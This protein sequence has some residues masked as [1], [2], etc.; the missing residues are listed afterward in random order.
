MIRYHARWV[1]PVDAASVPRGTVAVDGD[2]IAYVGPRAGAPP[3][4]DRDLGDVALLPGLVAAHTDGDHAAATLAGALACGVT[5]LGACTTDGSLLHAMRDVGLRGVAYLAV[6]GPAPADRAASF[7]ALREG[8]ARLRPFETPLVRLGVAPRSA[9]VVHE[10]LLVDA[11]AYAVAERLPLAI[12]AAETAEEIAFLRDAAGPMADALR[13]RG[14]EVMRRAHSPVHLLVELGIAVVARPLLVGGAWFDASDAALAAL[15]GCAIAYGAPPSDRLEPDTVSATQM[16]QAGA[17]VGLALTGARSSTLLAEAWRAVSGTGSQTG[18][19]TGVDLAPG[20]RALSLVTLDG[21]RALGL[22][23]AVGS[24]T[25]GKQADLAAFPL[26]S[27][28]SSDPVEA[29]L[30]SPARACFVAVG[31]RV[32]VDDGAGP[33]EPRPG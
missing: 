29:L 20:D 27:A 21:A 31:G 3:G 33:G 19:G 4:V 14:V 1:V 9:A 11:C 12:H 17:Q 28:A 10:D 32:L 22:D 30:R 8:V 13:A 24:L 15:Y 2:A 6:V 16:M 25:A 7:A 18:A 5:T 23:A 26:G